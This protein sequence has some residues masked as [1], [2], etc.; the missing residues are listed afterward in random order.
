MAT[1]PRQFRRQVAKK[2]VARPIV[3]FHLDWVDDEDMEK[4]IRTDTFHA[5][6]PT[7]ERLFLL[8]AAAGEEDTN[9]TRESAALLDLFRDVLP[10][11]EFLVLL[12][13][14]KDPDDDVNLEMLQDVTAWLMEEW[15]TFPTEPSSDSS[16]SPQRTGSR[17]TGRVRGEGSIH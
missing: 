5:A 16:V 17:S 2:K 1:A 6:A 13:R 10:R 14:L 8:A 12:E 4:V 11:S 15:S 7:D 9:V 3:D